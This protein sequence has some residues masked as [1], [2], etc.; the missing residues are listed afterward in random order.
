MNPIYILISSQTFYRKIKNTTTNEFLIDDLLNVNLVTCSTDTDL[1]GIPDLAEDSNKNLVYDDDDTDKD[2]LKNYEDADDDGD[3]ILT[4]NEDYNANGD[5]SDD[6]IDSSGVADYLEF[7]VTLSLEDKKFNSIILY[8]NPVN[9]NL[10]INSKEELESIT[11]YN[12][13]G[14]VIQH[15]SFKKISQTVKIST[16]NLSQGVYFIKIKSGSGNEYH[17]FIKN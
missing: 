7:N 17:R 4:I 13:S 3:G 1:D 15:V 2:G 8:P 5:P 6:D 16:V 9:E 14:I 11:I 12:I 10:F